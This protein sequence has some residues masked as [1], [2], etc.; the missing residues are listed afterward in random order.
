[1]NRKELSEIRR[2]ITPDRNC[3]YRIYGCYVNS[4]KQIISEFEISPGLMGEEE[5]KKYLKILKKVTSGT[6]GKNLIDIDFTNDQVLYGDKHRLLMKLKSS[7][8]EDEYARKQLYDLIIPAV[9]FDDKN[10]LI[11]MAADNYD[12]SYKGKDEMA[13][14]D[15]GAGDVH[16]YIICAVCPVK[17]SSVELKYDAGE[18]RFAGV[19]SGQTVSLPETGF[20]F[21]EFTDR[22][23]D[24][25]RALYYTRKPSEIN[26]KFIEGVFD[27]GIPMSAPKQKHTFG[28][29]LNEAL[30]DECSMDVVQNL[31]DEM[32]AVI[33]EN[34]ITKNPENPEISVGEVEMILKGSGL[35]EEKVRTFGA[36]C[37]KYF[38][39]GAVLNPNN[40]IDSRHFVVETPDVKIITAP[41]NS[42]LIQTRVIDGRKYILVSADEGVT[43]NG[44]DVSIDE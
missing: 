11:L 17:S 9:D 20:M 23:G 7:L 34:K 8:A 12:I 39:K 41:E 43:V 28:Y 31:H 18:G 24:I 36:E 42:H 10:F 25:Y 14:E 27:S 19:P 4:N 1:M 5:N 30:E 33:E 3:I 44:I 32:N 2:R 16:Q 21:P 26:S 37:E 22:S 35:D 13:G 38:G 6:Y 40:L 29:A 15:I